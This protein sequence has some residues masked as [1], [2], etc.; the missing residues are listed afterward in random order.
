MIAAILLGSLLFSGILAFWLTSLSISV[1]FGKEG[2]ILTLW[3]LIS[4]GMIGM[5]ARWQNGSGTLSLRIRDHS[6]WST[7]LKQSTTTPTSKEKSESK[8]GGIESI[9]PEVREIL[10]YLRR[11]LHITSFSCQVV[12]GFPSASTTGMVFGYFQA[13]RGFLA[14][15]S[16]LRL[17]MTPDFDRTVCEGEGTLVLEV[18]YP[19]ILA[20]RILRIALRP[21]MREVLFRQKG[22]F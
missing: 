18:R 7:P 2:S 3:G 10:G 1:T 4:W 5:H 12:L 14:P 15:L 13:I 11:H 8:V 22:I 16:R 19:L 9:F 17:H 21:K 6:V 20:Y